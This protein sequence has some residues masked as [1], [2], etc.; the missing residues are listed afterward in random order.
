MF[1]IIWYYLHIF[2]LNA[3]QVTD[4]TFKI[5]SECQSTRS[6][7]WKL[8]KMQRKSLICLNRR[9]TG[10]ADQ[11]VFC[12]ALWGPGRWQK[13][14]QKFL[15]VQLAIR[16]SKTEVDFNKIKQVGQS[17]QISYQ[18]LKS[19]GCFFLRLFLLEPWVGMIVA[20]LSVRWLPAPCATSWAR[21]G[22][23]ESSRNL[24]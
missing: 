18:S 2:R 5:L 20:R 21:L 16:T 14:L 4:S 9:H 12:F 23:R 15:G 10:T 22:K 1:T 11:Y 19:Q 17:Y 6:Q 7:V 3:T 13:L 8:P 24:A